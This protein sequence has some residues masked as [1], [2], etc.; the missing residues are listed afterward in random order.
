MTPASGHVRGALT[1]AL[2]ECLS[3][4]PEHRARLRARPR[5]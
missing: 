4:R 3:L 5:R 1:F 2:R